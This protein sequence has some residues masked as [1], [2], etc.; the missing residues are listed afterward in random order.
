MEEGGL[1]KI[2]SPSPKPVR[3]LIGG[4]VVTGAFAVYALWNG[5]PGVVGYYLRTVGGHLYITD[6]EAARAWR[7]GWQVHVE[8]IEMEKDH[9]RRG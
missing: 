3:V 2:V 8:P 6:G 5:G 4:R 1:I 7:I 9:A